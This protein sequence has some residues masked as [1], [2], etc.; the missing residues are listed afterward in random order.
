MGQARVF[1]KSNNKWGTSFLRI[2]VD[3]IQL[4]VAVIVTCKANGKGNFRAKLESSVVS[5]VVSVGFL[6]HTAFVSRN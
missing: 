1:S 4:L 5:G 2:A 3:R 6:P